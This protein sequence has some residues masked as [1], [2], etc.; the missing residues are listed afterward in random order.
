MSKL[1]SPGIREALLAE[2]NTRPQFGGPPTPDSVLTGAARRLG[3]AQGRPDLEQALLTQWSELF[4]TGLLA[5]GLNLSNPN[6][7][8]FHLTE[9]GRQALANLTRDP[10]NPAGYLRHLNSVAHVD[11][12]AQSYLS[13]A[14][15]CYVAGFFKAAAVMT[16]VAAENIILNLRDATVQK[17]ASL[18]RPAP[19]GMSDWRVKT[20]S[21]SLHQFLNGHKAK[22]TRALQEEFEAY[23][24]AFTQQIRA[25][26][27]E[28]GHPTSI[29]PITS[30][31]V[32]AS[33]LIFPELAKLA[34][35]L[36]HW[37]KKGLA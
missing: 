4:R 35:S 11:P 8:F 1:T 19:K 18:D 3:I 14:L 20:I 12:V 16:G 33:L 15:D 21:D 37:V 27:N 34:N 6:P 25:T 30:D 24:S 5:W 13:E 9:P 29:D 32:H 22:F 26:R 10:S 7:P 31:A 28:V 2:L 36:D 23:W 17:L